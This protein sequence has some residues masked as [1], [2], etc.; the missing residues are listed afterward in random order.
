MEHSRSPDTMTR[1]PVADSID[2]AEV[3]ANCHQALPLNADVQD[4][5]NDYI[6][7]LDT[8]LRAL[9][10]YVSTSFLRPDSHFTLSLTCT[11]SIDS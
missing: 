9:N 7:S 3:I 1:V 2:L 5:M 6:L 11:A 8:N 10:K 4:A